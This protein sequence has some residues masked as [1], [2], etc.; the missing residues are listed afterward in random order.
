MKHRGTSDPGCRGTVRLGVYQDGPFLRTE[1]EGRERVAPDPVDAP[2][3]RFVS[4]VAD[5]FDSLAVFARIAGVG[6][7]ADAQLLP[8]DTAIVA[9]PDYGSLRHLGSVARAAARTASAFWRGLERVDLVWA[10]GPHPFQ[11]VLVVLAR[12]RR[13][14]VVLGVRQDTPAYFRARL[15]SKRWQPVVVL[16][17]A[18]DR[19]HRLLARHVP[20]T[21]VGAANASRYSGHGR[22]VLVMQPS[23]VRAADVVGTP[24]RH[25][26][27]EVVSLLTVGRIDHEKNP[28]LLV[29]AMAKLE[30]RS[31]GRYRLK[32]VGIGPQTQDVLAL[33]A[34]LGVDERIELLGYLPFGPDLLDLYRSAHAFVHVSLTEG[35]PQVLVEALASGTPI[36]ATDVGGVRAALDDGEAGLLVPPASSEALVEALLRLDDSALRS[37]LTA[38]GLEVARTRTLE[39]EA[40]RV[41]EFLRGA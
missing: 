16:V 14:R 23:L 10:F 41:A 13:K 1:V 22:R 18:L 31:P 37:R 2:F 33:A 24:L 7:R 29:E 3:L 25:D 5:E 9:L 32:W 26:W 35:V 34:D 20:A 28:L 4:E 6:G 27:S 11:L 21:V 40:G 30:R 36:V 39:V 19:A 38:R 17:D 15:P 8:A 12:L